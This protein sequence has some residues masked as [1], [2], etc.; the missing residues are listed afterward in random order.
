MVPSLRY[1]TYLGNNGKEIDTAMLSKKFFYLF[2]MKMTGQ[3][4][5]PFQVQ[6]IEAFEAMSILLNEVQETELTGVRALLKSYEHEN[7]SLVERQVTI[8]KEKLVLTES[9]VDVSASLCIRNTYKALCKLPYFRS[10]Y[11]KQDTLSHVLE[12]LGW[13]PARGSRSRMPYQGTV[14][15]GFMCI[16]NSGKTTKMGKQINEGVITPKGISHI[17][18]NY[19]SMYNKAKARYENK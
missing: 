15:A 16:I 5:L 10:L 18:D 12:L 13:I 8:E 3:S 2:V 1:C 11:K 17:R 14:D 7:L 6:Y 4:I 19:E 9:L